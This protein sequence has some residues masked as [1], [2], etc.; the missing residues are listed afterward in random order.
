M[1]HRYLCLAVGLISNLIACATTQNPK[2]IAPEYREQTILDK[3]LVVA[4]LPADLL[5]P[6]EAKLLSRQLQTRNPRQTFLAMW[7]DNFPRV[8]QQKS[9][10]SRVISD[11][12]KEEP[13]LRPRTITLGKKSQITLSVPSNGDKILF[14]R[15][16]ADFVLVLPRIRVSSTRLYGESGQ[17]TDLYLGYLAHW[18]IWDNNAG[19]LASCGIIDIFDPANTENQLFQTVKDIATAIIERGPF[20]KPPPEKTEGQG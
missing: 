12:Y 18:F 3:T 7:I 19:R 4:P 5:S 1:K 16:Q 11:H 20:E 9:T 8:L 13:N 17:F 15:T 10:F 6:K 2:Y 14:N